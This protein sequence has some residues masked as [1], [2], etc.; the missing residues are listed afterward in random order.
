MTEPRHFSTTDW[1]AAGI[2]FGMAL[3]VYFF[4]L[5]PTITLE[6]SGQLVV[7]LGLALLI[8]FAGGRAP[9]RDP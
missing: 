6:Y 1:K 2:A 5:A 3:A 7:S 8:R 4:T 9:R